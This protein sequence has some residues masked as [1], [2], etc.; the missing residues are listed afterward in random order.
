MQCTLCV[1]EASHLIL[2][3]ADCSLMLLSHH[4]VHDMLSICHV[5]I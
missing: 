2:K 5:Y 1:H 4:A 3:P